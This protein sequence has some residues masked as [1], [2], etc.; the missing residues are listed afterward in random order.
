M[1]YG[2]LAGRERQ[3]TPQGD[4]IDARFRVNCIELYWVGGGGY[5][6]NK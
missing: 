3:Y 2:S 4:N 1:Y 6:T 5:S